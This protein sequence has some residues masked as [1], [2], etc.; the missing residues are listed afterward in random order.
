MRRGRPGRR[1]ALGLRITGSLRC[2]LA[3]AAM[4]TLVALSS[5]ARADTLDDVEAGIQAWADAYNS[6]DPDRVVAR[7][8][9][10]AVFWGTVSPTLRDTRAEIR[11]YF[12]GLSDRP[13][14]RVEIGEHRVQLFDGV[15]LAA[16]FYTFTDVVNG[17]AVTRPARFSFALRL[18]DGEWLLTQH[19][20]SR[21]PE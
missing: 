2:M 4:A 14:A 21:I 11:D 6:H 8:H 17:E 15:A 13:A 5:V 9:A 3:A 16:G 10:D 20:S 7:Y 12:S 19:H 1:R 18:T